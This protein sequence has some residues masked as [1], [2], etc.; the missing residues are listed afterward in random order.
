VS[1]ADSE[2]VSQSLELPHTRF[3]RAVDGALDRVGRA[4]SWIWLLLLVV[5][6]ANV[7]LRYAF[8]AGRIEF[9]ELQWHLY[10]VGF[11][12]GLSY[13]MQAD[14]HVRVD[15]LRERL[16]PRMQAWIELYGLLLLVLPFAALIL[17]FGVPFVADSFQ[18][19][20]RS[21][22]PGGLPYRWLIKSTLPAGFA[23]LALAAVSRIL[24]VCAFLF[25][26]AK[27]GN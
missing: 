25:G 16:E 8:G 22:S 17:I 5:I 9:E 15:V 24:R 2:R 10:S 19:G 21:P 3:T 18:S 26:P 23:L 1:S 14:A 20:E 13:C 6:V 11:L 27:S 12:T 7:T 4:V